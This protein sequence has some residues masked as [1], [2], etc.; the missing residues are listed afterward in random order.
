MTITMKKTINAF[1]ILLLFSLI[2]SGSSAAA[3]GGYIVESGYDHPIPKGAER[4]DPVPISFW[5]LPLWVMILHITCMPLETLVSLK[6]LAYLGCK[7][8]SRSNVLDHEVRLKIYDYIR[9]NP[10][11]H[12]SDIAN[13]T[14]INRG[15]LRYH[16]MMLKTQN[17]LTP[18]KTRG[19]V[20]YFLNDSTYGKKEKVALAALKN[21]KHRRIISEI[22]NCGQITHGKLAEKIGVS[23]THDQLAYQASEGRGDCQSRYVWRA[24]GIQY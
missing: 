18:H 22:L 16:L 19:R 3:S 7:R 10:G 11:V 23:R 14:N 5:Q 8:I 13:E 24:Y 2:L 15:T 17:R 4:H 6:A 1:A 12:Y 9:K 21:E 20:H